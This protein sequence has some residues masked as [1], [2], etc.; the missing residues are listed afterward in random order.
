MTEDTSGT[1]AV[2]TL[3]PIGRDA[4]IACGLLDNAGLP[5]LPAT[6]LADLLKI[7]LEDL[8]ALVLSEEFLTCEV[9][10]R[11]TDLLDAQPYWSSLPVILLVDP[12][13]RRTVSGTKD[14]MTSFSTRPGVVML[15]R[16]MRTAVFISIARAAFDARQRP[17]QLRDELEARRRAESRAQ[18]L[19]G[20]MAHRVSRTPSRLQAASRRRPSARRT[21]SRRAGARF[22]VGWPRWPTDQR[23]DREGHCVFDGVPSACD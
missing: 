7:P 4:E 16:P 15:E 8:S 19:A 18:T 23:L 2:L 13:R 11:L 21:C 14:H 5:C 1:R 20:E 10:R 6:D 22:S 3:A 12:E 17:F 9:V